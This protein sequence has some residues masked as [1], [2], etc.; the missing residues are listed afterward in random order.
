MAEMSWGN[1]L[2][3]NSMSMGRA[4]AMK[5]QGMPSVFH[6]SGPKLRPNKSKSW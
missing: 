5:Y 3:T 6:W 2:A 1:F 4:A